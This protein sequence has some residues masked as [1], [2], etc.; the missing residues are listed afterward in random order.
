VTSYLAKRHF[1][2]VNQQ[3]SL[4]RLNH[5]L[6]GR[7]AHPE[8]MQGTADCHHEIADALLP[9]ADP[10]F[11]DATALDTAVDM[12]DPQ[13]AVGEG[14]IGHVLL[15]RQLLSVNA[16]KPR[17]CKSRLPAGKGYGVASAMRL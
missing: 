1:L 3:L 16:R 8:I 17:S 12:L 10:V 5:R 9:Q 14:L 13:P 15:P 11:D 4:S 7:D 2:S 6:P